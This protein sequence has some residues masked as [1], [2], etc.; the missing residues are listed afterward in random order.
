MSTHPDERRDR[1]VLNI[2]AAG[3]GVASLLLPVVGMGAAVAAIGLGFL[4]ARASRRGEARYAGAGI[5]GL[6]AGVASLAVTM[7]LAAGWASALAE[8]D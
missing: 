4:G 1:S 2:I 5:A 6:V 3:V 8:F 7:W